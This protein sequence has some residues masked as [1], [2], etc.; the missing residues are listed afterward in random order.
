VS[1][2]VVEQVREEQLK[3]KQHGYKR[4][5]LGVLCPAM[6]VRCRFVTRWV[7]HQDGTTTAPMT[8]RELNRY[9]KEHA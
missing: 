6:R 4:N 1:K 2:L 7:V 3:L 8:K 5:G 9:M